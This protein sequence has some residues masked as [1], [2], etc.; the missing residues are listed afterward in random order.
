MSD[1]LV[2]PGPATAVS[3]TEPPAGV[4][5]QPQEP[6]RASHVTVR[7]GSRTVLQDVDLSIAAGELVALVGENGAGKTT[8]MSCLTGAL[9]PSAGTVSIL[10]RDAATAFREGLLAAVWQDL[11]LC[12]NLSILGNVFLGREPGHAFLARQTMRRRTRATLEALGLDLGDLGRRV[13]ELSGGDRQAVAITRAVIG[14]PRVLVLDEPTAALDTNDTGRVERLLR[15]LRAQQVAILLISHRMDQVFGLADRVV[16][17]RHGR[18][19][20]NV[21]TVATHADDVIALMSGLQVES[22]A[23]RHLQRLSTLVDQ[24]AG[25]DPSASLPLIVSSLATAFGQQQWCVHLLDPRDCRGLR[26]AAS[27]GLSPTM[28]DRLQEVPVGTAGGPIGEAAERGLPVVADDLRPGAPAWV[29]GDAPS[30]AWSV[31]IVGTDGVL[32]VLTG[33]CPARGRPRKEQLHLVSVYASLAS[34][35][36]ERERLLRDVTCRNTVLESLRRML[37]ALTGREQLQR[38]VR[39]AL[40]QLRHDLGATEVAL[41]DCDARTSIAL[42]DSHRAPGPGDEDA[43]SPGDEDAPSPGDEDAPSPGDE[44]APGPGD[45]DGSR[46]SGPL[47]D[48]VRAVPVTGTWTGRVRR[49]SAAT[50]AIPLVADGAR[51]LLAARWDS[52][53]HVDAVAEDLLEKAAWSLRLAVERENARS[54]Q[55]EAEALRRTGAIQRDFVQRLS[56]ELRTPLTAIRGY[57]ST[58]LQTDVDWDDGSRRRFL[59]AIAGESAR[60]GRLVGDLLDSSTIEAGVLPVQPDWCDVRTVLEAASAA[61]AGHTVRIRATDLPPLWADHD[62]LEQVLVN[63]LDNAVR[64]GADQVSMTARMDGNGGSPQMLIEVADNGPGVPEHSWEECFQA[65]TRGDTRATGAGLGLA[66]CRGIVTAHGGR[67]G[68]LP[69]PRG[70]TVRVS[71]PLDPQHPACPEDPLPGPGEEG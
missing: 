22:V 1:P 16:V 17:L 38:G 2:R 21:S 65:G 40:E 9:H 28:L 69:V 5:T 68:F 6:V 18:V 66:I 3:R 53:G 7:F 13:G 33:L 58:L 26:L 70:T 23:R 12:D 31:P 42:V 10:G 32:G 62:R 35:A 8:L 34:T 64:H 30:S 11:A 44:D 61:V 41:F 25:V 43:P 45:E 63:L 57:A 67:I 20:G 36:L 39:G 27:I 50:A 24:L 49:L 52:A 15:R 59:A 47:A 54:A 55:S 14:T 46:W 51:L 60:M 56:H 71:L 29:A 48:A 19:V 4:V 37:D